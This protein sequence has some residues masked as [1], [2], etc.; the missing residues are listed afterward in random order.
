MGVAGLHDGHRTTRGLWVGIAVGL[1][2]L[3]AV[4]IFLLA[5]VKPH[6]K[7]SW[8]SGEG[9]GFTG[10]ENRIDQTCQSGNH[11]FAPGIGQFRYGPQLSVCTI[12]LCR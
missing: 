12:R 4:A 7:N 10:L 11:Q 2:L 3:A 8:Y 5:Y 1:A 9:P 6:M